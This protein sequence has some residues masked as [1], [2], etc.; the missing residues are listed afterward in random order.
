MKDF[1]KEMKDDIAAQ[2]KPADMPKLDA[3]PTIDDP[4]KVKNEDVKQSALPFCIR[5]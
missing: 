2:R 4:Q 3:A 1:E 5:G